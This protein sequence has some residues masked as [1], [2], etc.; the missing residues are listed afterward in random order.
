MNHP[1][2]EQEGS[3]FAKI[4]LSFT[5]EEY[6]NMTLD[7]HQ[8]YWSTLK[9]SFKVFRYILFSVM[10]LGIAA[11]LFSKIYLTFV[12]NEKYWPEGSLGNIVTNIGGT[13]LVV[14]LV[15]LIF[16][17]RLFLNQRGYRKDRKKSADKI[18]GS[19]KLNYLLYNDGME[20]HEPWQEA[21]FAWND[22]AE[23][24][25]YKKYL[26]FAFTHTTYLIIIPIQEI[27][28]HEVVLSELARLRN[29]HDKRS[30]EV[31]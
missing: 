12:L 16:R 4:E 26:S 27:P 10:G 6:Y 28:N 31:L 3:Y 14:I 22:F 13:G 20:V 29:F 1:I 2:S 17:V 19:A 9:N 11:L 25:R 7:Y 5:K 23:I 30:K 24:V 8:V 15:Y 18:Q 21:F